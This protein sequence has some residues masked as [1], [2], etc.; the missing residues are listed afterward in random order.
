M[1]EFCG[2][3]EIKALKDD[4]GR[5]RVERSDIADILSNHFESVFVKESMC[6]LPEFEKRINLSFGIDS[7]LNKINEYEIKKRLKNSKG[8]KSMGPDQIHSMILKECASEFAIPL[9]KL[10]RESIKKGKIP[11]S[12]RYANISLIFKKGH[13]TLRSSYRPISLT[14]V[15]SKI[16]ERI[17]KEELLGHSVYNILLSKAQHGFV[18]A[19]SCLSNLLETLDFI[20]SNLVEEHCVGLFEGV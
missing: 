19:K 16:L 4:E 12:W 20:T 9:T 17:I 7:V 5:I 11:N 15:I 13:R 1:K 10:F 14:S 3:E 18:S 2:K 8:S 6:P